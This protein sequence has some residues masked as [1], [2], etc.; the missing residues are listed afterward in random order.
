MDPVRAVFRSHSS[1]DT[2]TAVVRPF[3]VMVCGPSRWAL[4]ITSESRA[5]ASATVQAGVGL[6]IG[7]SINEHDDHYNHISVSSSNQLR[8]FF[9]IESYHKT[10]V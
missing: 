8:G 3:L 5:L 7:R 10:V 6:G 2:T 1:M 9:N 4:S